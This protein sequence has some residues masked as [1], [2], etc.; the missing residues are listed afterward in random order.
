M[1]F[2]EAFHDPDFLFK[3]TLIVVSVLVLILPI[4][5]VVEVTIKGLKAKSNVVTVR[6]EKEGYTIK[7]K[8]DRQEYEN[9]IHKKKFDSAI[10]NMDKDLSEWHDRKLRE[11]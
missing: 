5:V 3:L 10:E 4:A 1:V 7:Y 8:M 6:E 2:I 9:K 11:K